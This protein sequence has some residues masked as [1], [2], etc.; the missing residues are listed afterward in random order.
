MMWIARRAK[1]QRARTGRARKNVDWM[2]RQLEVQL[3]EGVK[4][5]SADGQIASMDYYCTW[6]YYHY[7]YAPGVLE[8]HPGNHRIT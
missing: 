6:Y 8:A 1:R 4:N 7:Y 5:L 3:L 2:E